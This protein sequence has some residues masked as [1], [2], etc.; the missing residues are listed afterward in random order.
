MPG[1]GLGFAFVQA[2][3]EPHH[4]KGSSWI[5]PALLSVLTFPRLVRVKEMCS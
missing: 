4:C 1:S 3:E 2:P 5:S